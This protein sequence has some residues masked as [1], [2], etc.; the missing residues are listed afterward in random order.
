MNSGT[1][2]VGS[3]LVRPA[4]VSENI[5]CYSHLTVEISPERASDSASGWFLLRRLNRD[6]PGVA[7]GARVD[8]VFLTAATTSTYTTL[9]ALENSKM[10]ALALCTSATEPTSPV[11][12]KYFTPT[13]EVTMARTGT[14]VQL[15][16]LKLGKRFKIQNQPT[17][18][19]TFLWAR[20]FDTA[21]DAAVLPSTVQIRAIVDL[22]FSR[23][24]S[25]F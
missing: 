4:D 23:P 24:V 5:D 2:V 6:A 13:R 8:E 7:S 15:N 16:Q 22:S 25:Q 9:T 10:L 18:A 14:G 21:D 11:Y 20:Y 12:L 17:A 1:I 3:R 19:P